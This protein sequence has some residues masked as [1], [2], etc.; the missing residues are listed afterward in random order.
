LV[1]KKNFTHI[2]LLSPFFIYFII[3]F[4]API[5]A[6]FIYSFWIAGTTDMIPTFTLKNYIEVIIEPLYRSIMLRSILIGFITG[7]ICVAAS[8]PLAY[9]LTF[10]YKKL[11]DVVLYL[12]LI[13]LFSSYLVRVYAW[14]AILGNNGLINTVL[15]NI[16]VI[17]E[18]LKFLLYSPTA[19]V[20][21]L[22]FILLPFTLLP[23]F[24]SLQNINPDLIEAAKDLGANGAK[25]FYKITLPLSMPG[26][27]T[28]FIF[29]FILSSG[30]YVTPQLVGGTTGLMIGRIIADQFGFVFNWPLGSAMAYF[31]IFVSVLVIYILT[32]ITRL[33]KLNKK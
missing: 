18:P 5:G 23:I 30:D 24:S 27:M 21:T 22:V 20:I 2:F 19:I 28:G 31:L 12:I 11:Q 17:K 15:K 14:K 26:V 3:F 29:A 8:Y 6:L 32:W 13:A 10:K 25:A 7:I 1:K 4:I 16:G 33:L 9:A